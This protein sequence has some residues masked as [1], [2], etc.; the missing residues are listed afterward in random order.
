MNILKS[1]FFGVGIPKIAKRITPIQWLILAMLTVV[2]LFSALPGYVVGKWAWSEPP[3]ITHIKQLTKLQKKGLTIPNWEILKQQTVAIGAGKWSVQTAQV[4]DHEPFTLLLLPQVYYL[5]QPITDW[6]DINGVE[7]WST[8]SLQTLNFQTASSPPAKVQARFFRAWNKE[9]VAIVQWYAWPRGGSADP[10]HWFWK[11]QQAQI[12][13]QRLP[14]VAVCL[15]IPID[16]LSDLKENRAFVL[17]LA[18]SVQTA[19]DSQIFKAM[20]P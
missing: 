13:K 12:S 4:P 8:D 17:S 3:Q 18:Q 5:N 14:W 19:L 1:Q 11:D 15:I 20:T 6:L 9:T 2:L 16:P 10:S 7:R